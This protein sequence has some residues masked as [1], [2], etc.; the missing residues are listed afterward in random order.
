MISSLGQD[1]VI[2]QLAPLSF[3]ASTFEIWG[4]LLNGGTLAVVSNPR[5]RRSMTSSAISRVME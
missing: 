2:L 1:E 4:A 3:D 5:P